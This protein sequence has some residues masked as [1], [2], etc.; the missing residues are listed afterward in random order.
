METAYSEG[1][2]ESCSE[3]WSN[4]PDGSLYYDDV[5]YSEDECSSSNDPDLGGDLAD[6]DE[7]R[8]QGTNDG[9]D[10]AFDLSP[11]GVLC[12]GEDCYSRS[13]F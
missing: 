7:A 11:A 12:W 4:S 10:A 2:E 8:Y 3:V 9:F 5:A 13:D 1:F 6:E